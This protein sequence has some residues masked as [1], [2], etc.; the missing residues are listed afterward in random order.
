MPKTNV[1]CPNCRQSIVGDIDQ[2]FDVGE[3]PAAKQKILAGS[4]NLINCPYCGYQ[5]QA[6][7]PIVYHDPHKEI[8]LTYLPP[9]LAIPRD[10]QER[11]IGSLI[12]QAMNRLPQEQRKAYLLNPQS[13]LTM[14]GLV[15]RVLESEGI[16]KEMI[17]AQKD[18]LQLIQ[19]FS[20]LKDEEVINQMAAEEDEKIDFGLLWFTTKIIRNS[21]GKW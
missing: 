19:R 9:E 6:S 10:E 21:H 11:V 20:E 15:E 8:L 18:R 13:T 12:N 1:S 14:Q 16:T 4:F 17:E 5:G 7:T 3:D 2:L